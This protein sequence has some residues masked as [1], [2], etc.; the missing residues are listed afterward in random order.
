MRKDDALEI[1]VELNHLE[2]KLFAF[3]GVRVI[4]LHE[5]LGSGETFYA[6]LKLH[7]GTLVHEFDD[8]TLVYAAFSEYSGKYVPRILLELLVTERETTV[9]RVDVEY[10]NLDVGTNLSKF[11]GVL[12]LLGPREV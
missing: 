2:G 8:S 10:N 5:V 11:R 9:D 1:L 12:D 6:I 3:L 4:L 7:Y